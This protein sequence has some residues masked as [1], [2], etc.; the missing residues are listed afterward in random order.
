MPGSEGQKGTPRGQSSG[1]RPKTCPA[2]ITKSHTTPLTTPRGLNV[3][4]PRTPRTPRTSRTFPRTPLPNTIDPISKE[5]R[6]GDPNHRQC[7]PNYRPASAYLPR[8]NHSKY[9]EKSHTSTRTIRYTSGMIWAVSHSIDHFYVH[10]I[11]ETIYNKF[12]L[13]SFNYKFIST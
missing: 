6:Y 7:A 9:Y 8:D 11:L 10:F 12:L 13:S 4:T 2:A 5:V 3:T 1:S